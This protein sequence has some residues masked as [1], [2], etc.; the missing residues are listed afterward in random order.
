[1]RGASPAPGRPRPVA[2]LTGSWRPPIRGTVALWVAVLSPLAACGFPSDPDPWTEKLYV[3][4]GFDDR[5]YVVNGTTGIV[6]DT[7]RLDP[8]LGEVDEP[9]GVAVHLGTGYWYA[10]VSHGTPT[11]WK[12]ELATDRLV[13]RVALPQ[14][15]ASRIGLRP[16]GRTALIPDYF[17]G[18]GGRPTSVAIVSLDELE[19]RGTVELCEA[20]HDAAYAPDGRRAALTCS[21]S[22]EVVLFDPEDSTA[23]QRTPLEPGARPMNLAWS[24]DGSRVFA[25]LMG[26]DQVVQIDGA[27]GVAQGRVDTG[28]APAQIALEP[29]GTRL[30]VAN[31]RGGTVSLVD[32]RGLRETRRI[33]VPGPSPHGVAWSASGDRLFVTYEGATDGT[34]GIIS[35]DVEG[36]VLWHTP[37]GA[38]V[39]GVASG[40]VPTPPR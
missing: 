4:S 1:M 31:R 26:K 7:L 12:F 25:S 3:T 23:A 22:D 35:L 29:D 9:H 28:E 6:L 38:Y 8:R 20:P 19:V 30:A 10:T 11:L 5:V 36:T 18:A 33:P 27:S 39:L 2:G 17:R 34:G 32:T 13:G 16:D 15:G 40:L 14:T 21:L 37:L 24:H